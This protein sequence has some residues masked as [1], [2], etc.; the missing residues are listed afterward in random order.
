MTTLPIERPHWRG[1]RGVNPGDR[2]YRVTLTALALLL[3]LLL[4]T[5]VGQLLLSAWPSYPLF[6]IMARQAT[7]GPA[8]AS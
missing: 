7:S 1:L 2:V 6:P 4:V 3:P 5:L 8:R